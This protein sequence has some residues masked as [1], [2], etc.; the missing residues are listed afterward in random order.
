MATVITVAG[1]DR[2]SRFLRG[3][4]TIN[5]VT[6]GRDTCSITFVSKDSGSI[7]RPLEGEE[8]LVSIDGS[9]PAGFGGTIRDVE[10]AAVRDPDIAWACTV[11][12]TNFT[13]LL[14]EV[15]V[16]D[17][18][19]A[20][21]LW[22]R[23]YY[24]HL[25]FLSPR[26]STTYGGATT[27]GPAL[28]ASGYNLRSL[29]DVF[30]EW[31][32]L[33]GYMFNVGGDKLL[34]WSLPGAVSAPVN[35]SQANSGLVNGSAQSVRRRRSS[36]VKVTRAYV[37]VQAPEGTA[38]D[39]AIPVTSELFTSVAGQKEFPLRY[40]PIVT[41]PTQIKING[42]AAV[43]LPSGVYSWDASKKAIVA[44]SAP[45]AG[46]T[47]EVVSYESRYACTVVYDSG[48]T[49]I[50]ERGVLDAAAGTT[51]AQAWEVGA[52]YVAEN[53]D[54][55]PQEV[56]VET[57]EPGFY[58][59]MAVT[60][61]FAVRNVSGTYWVLGITIKDDPAMAPSV[62]KRHRYTL[63]CV[64]GTNPV[65]TWQRK[66]KDKLGGGSGSGSVVGG[67]ISGGGGSGY[68]GT[69]PLATERSTGV[70]ISGYTG[71]GMR[72]A[73]DG[74]KVP[75]GATVRLRV[76]LRTD[77]AGTQVNVKLRNITGGA[78]ASTV[79]SSTSTT[80]S[81][82]NVLTL[83]LGSGLKVYELW[84]GGANANAAVYAVGAVDVVLP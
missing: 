4:L 84:V 36:I 8:L 52:A 60:L 58:V 26:F 75:A 45:T 56:F 16:D 79:I 40:R 43:T 47:I 20:N 35:L 14:D 9:L 33:T 76:S 81:E 53:S 24:Y 50:R 78:D 41:A 2:T 34:S 19:I 73:L 80:W 17:L 38:S 22:D 51:L 64:E 55:Q 72:L 10:E 54:A 46:T 11:R 29:A 63:H 57:R 39:A 42:A 31:S 32:S 25:N 1:V 7:Y 5:K 62:A 77:S 21:G 59:L 37:R 67:G 44:S 61:S 18:W 15:M 71:V 28:V 68:A 48:A 65:R 6:N 69:Y 23:V 49:P 13:D 82:D 30:S 66:L 74:D 3:S 12:A 70:V 83:S 27:G